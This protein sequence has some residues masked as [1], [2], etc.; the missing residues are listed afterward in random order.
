MGISA[1]SDGLL[2]EMLR[3]AVTA[4]AAV[5]ILALMFLVAG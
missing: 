5:S 4:L 1:M 2:T 3:A